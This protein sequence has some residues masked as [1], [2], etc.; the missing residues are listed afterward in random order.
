MYMEDWKNW[1]KISSLFPNTILIISD[2][3]VYNITKDTAVFFTNWLDNSLA[4]SPFC[5]S[6]KTTEKIQYQ[7]DNTYA[8]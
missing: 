7:N 5:W 8:I 1:L 2:K 4:E 6:F 3:H